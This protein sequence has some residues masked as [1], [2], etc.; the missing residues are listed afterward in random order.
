MPVTSTANSQA[1]PSILREKSSPREG[2]HS[3]AWRTTPPWPTARYWRAVRTVAQR[4]TDPARKAAPFLAFWRRKMAMR[5]PMKGRATMA[6]RGRPLDMVEV[7]SF[8]VGSARETPKT[9]AIS[10]NMVDIGTKTQGCGPVK[11]TSGP[12]EAEV[13]RL[14][15][16][17]SP[18]ET[19][20]VA[21]PFR[22][23]S[24]GS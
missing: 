4:A 16:H 20:V 3:D 6:R 2:I 1:K 9:G 22:R 12:L 18:P 23:S 13:D 21:T 10:P 19:S 24:V 15:G 11:L 14:C 17:R 7:V 8:R 5:L